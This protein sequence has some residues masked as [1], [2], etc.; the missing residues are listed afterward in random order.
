VAVPV[1]WGTL[2]VTGLPKVPGKHGKRMRRLLTDPPHEF[3]NAVTGPTRVLVTQP[4][5]TVRLPGA[6]PGAS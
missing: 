4:G 6:V 3:A 2:A 5:E 1:H